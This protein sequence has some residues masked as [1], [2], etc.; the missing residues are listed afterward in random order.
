MLAE[1]KTAK[2]IRKTTK[3]AVNGKAQTAA[4]YIVKLNAL[5]TKIAI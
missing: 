3:C 2:F 1:T 5:L 4:N